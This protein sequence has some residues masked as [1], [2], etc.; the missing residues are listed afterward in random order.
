MTMIDVFPLERLA[1][2]HGRA[3]DRSDATVYFSESTKRLIGHCILIEYQDTNQKTARL[4]MPGLQSRP[5]RF[6]L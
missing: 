2:R 3:H 1:L 4:N 6:E 5:W